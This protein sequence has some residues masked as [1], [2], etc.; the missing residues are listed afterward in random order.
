MTNNKNADAKDNHLKIG[1]V[2]Y[3]LVLS[4]IPLI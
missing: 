3:V 4:D 1:L 2:M